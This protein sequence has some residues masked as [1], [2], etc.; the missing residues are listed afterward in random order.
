MAL[1]YGDD[2]DVL[3]GEIASESVDLIYLDPTFNSQA[4]YN[5]TT[6]CSG[7]VGKAAEVRGIPKDLASALDLARR[8]KYQFQ[9]WAVSMVDVRPYGDRKKGPDTGIDRY[10]VP[11][12]VQTPTDLEALRA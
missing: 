8:D 3:R 5:A 7:S 9:W 2:L 10:P 11:D 6:Y 4:S 1:Y 12:V